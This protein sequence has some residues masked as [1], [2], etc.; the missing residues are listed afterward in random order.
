M[1][2]SVPTPRLLVVDDEPDL[3]TL[4]ELTLVREGY[5]VDCAGSVTEAW[6]LLAL[7]PYDLLITD[8]RLPDGNGMDLLARLES[9]AR[10]E[11]TIVITAFASPENA[12]EALKAGAY[13]Y[14]TKP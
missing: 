4:Y 1:S 10:A 14:L 2:P 9:A 3:R 7:Q 12:V 5:D 11:R 13:D 8:M 6:A